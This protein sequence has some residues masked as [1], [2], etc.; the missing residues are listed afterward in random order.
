V[1]TFA[2]HAAPGGLVLVEPWFAPGD[3][4]DDLRVLYRRAS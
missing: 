4:Q 1:A 3:W 2:R